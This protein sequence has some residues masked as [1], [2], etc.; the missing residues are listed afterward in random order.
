MQSATSA[1]KVAEPWTRSRSL[2]TRHGSRT[3]TRGTWTWS[4]PDDRAAPGAV[5][6]PPR[7]RGDAPGPS[8]ISTSGSS[9]ANRGSSSTAAEAPRLAAFEFAE[10]GG[11][12]LVGPVL[13]Q[14]GEQQVT[15]LEQ[16]EI[17]LVLDLRGRQQPRG[18][19]VE[20]R[21]RDDEELG[22]LAQVPFGRGAEVRD[23]LV[24]D[25]RQRDLG[26]VHLAGSR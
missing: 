9:A 7:P 24:G 2:M 15:R 10:V 17:L 21:G 23:E 3:L 19:E 14:P 8:L 6:S 11:G 22:G 1:R 5:P 12:Q 20:Q 16:R 25:L 18:L 26:D 13:Q 4:I